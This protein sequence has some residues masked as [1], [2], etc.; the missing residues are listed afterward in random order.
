MYLILCIIITNLHLNFAFVKAGHFSVIVLCA[1]AVF[2]KVSFT[3]TQLYKVRQNRLYTLLR[4]SHPPAPK[5]QWH[6]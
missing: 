5:V 1:V 4:E 6:M 3:A 2:L